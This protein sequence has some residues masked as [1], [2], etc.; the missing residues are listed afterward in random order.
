MDDAEAII[1]VILD[2]AELFR[3]AG[4]EAVSDNAPPTVGDIKSQVE[5]G[6]VWVAE[7]NASLIGC[8]IVRMVDGEPHIKQVSTASAHARQGIGRLLVAV[9]EDWA[10][11]AGHRRITLTAFTE[12]AWN[13]PYYRRLGYRTLHPDEL[14]PELAEARAHEA[15]LGLDVWGRCAMARDIA[16]ADKAL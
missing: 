1:E 13:G 2:A 15:R 4:M 5:N 8:I 6:R 10:R 9:A 11:S 12:V 14:G 3:K 7:I 16:T